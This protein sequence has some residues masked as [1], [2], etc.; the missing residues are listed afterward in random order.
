MK[1]FK[2][3][4]ELN[5]ECILL[6]ASQYK[7]DQWSYTPFLITK[8]DGDEGWYWGLCDVNNDEWGDI[9]DLKADLYQVIELP[10]PPIQ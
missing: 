7:K 8:I 3:K 5:K 10:E 4:P 6:T 9:D 2:E 1:W